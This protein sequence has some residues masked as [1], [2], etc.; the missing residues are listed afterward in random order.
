MVI[1]VGHTIEPTKMTTIGMFSLCIF[2][3]YTVGSTFCG[4]STIYCLYTVFATCTLFENN[5]DE[6]YEDFRTEAETSTITLA[7][8]KKRLSQTFYTVH[9]V[10]PNG[11]IAITD[12]LDDPEPKVSV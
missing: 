1:V 11:Y 5:R 4:C 10:H 9:C 3:L 6:S 12:F 8:I 7:I 2:K